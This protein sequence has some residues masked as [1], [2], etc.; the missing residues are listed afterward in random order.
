MAVE[1]PYQNLYQTTEGVMNPYSGYGLPLLSGNTTES[2]VPMYNNMGV[3]ADSFSA[4]ASV[5]AESG[6]TYA[7]HRLPVSRKRTRETV[8]PMMTCN[9]GP[10]VNGEW[11]GL[12]TFLGEDVS[13]Q[14]QQQQLEMQRSITQHTEKVRIEIEEK[15]KRHCRRIMAALE[16]GIL[17]K[18]K[19][20]DEEIEK[21]VKLNWAL[22]EKVKSLSLEGQLWRDLAQ[23]NEAA[24]QALQANL[25]QAL[26][27]HTLNERA[28]VAAVEDDA[29]SC[30]GS[31]EADVDEKDAGTP[32]WDR[33]CR[34]CGEGESRVLLLPCRH[35]C[36]CAVCGSSVHICPVC[37][38]L[39]NASVHVIMSG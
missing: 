12:F 9:N 36:L 8:N 2:F 34:H 3:I 26:A 1:S 20:K 10:I 5:K 19:A 21:M 35:L 22:E 16:Q 24:A 39:K 32:G 6:L 7:A 37:N 13:I 18:L 31:N 29:Q 15:K 30:C 33:R 27:A 4:K 25:D 14:I 38:T 23:T 11:C 28:K 17:N